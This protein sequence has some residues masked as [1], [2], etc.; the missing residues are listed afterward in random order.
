[1]FSKKL[2][3]SI[4]SRTFYFSRPL[5]LSV[6]LTFCRFS[7]QRAAGD[8]ALPVL[9]DADDWRR[10]EHGRAVWHGRG[11]LYAGA[12]CGIQSWLPTV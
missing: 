9:A 1:M 7:R 11:Q 12:A 8:A 3:A 6:F 2:N 5:I 4:V 10:A